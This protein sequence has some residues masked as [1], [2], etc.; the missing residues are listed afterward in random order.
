MVR[1]NQY[2]NRQHDKTIS[3]YAIS[4]INNGFIQHIIIYQIE[5]LNSADPTKI[6]SNSNPKKSFSLSNFNFCK[7]KVLNKSE[8]LFF[9]DQKQYFDSIVDLVNYYRKHSLGEALPMLNTLLGVPFKQA[10]RTWIIMD[11][12]KNIPKS[13]RPNNIV[14]VF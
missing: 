3:D 11:I 5:I 12:A 7:Q 10:I 2:S 1:H 8:T 13:W 14:E 9:K 6:H 4:N